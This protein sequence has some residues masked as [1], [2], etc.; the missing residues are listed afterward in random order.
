MLGSPLV[1]IRTTFGATFLGLIISTT[2][3]G[4]TVVQTWTYFLRYYNRDSKALKSFI[5]FVT[6]MDALQTIFSAYVNYWYLVLNFGNVE[7]LEISI[8]AFHTQVIFS[9]IIAS[10]VQLYYA[11]RVHRVSQSIICPTLIVA[12]VTL[13]FSVGMYYA[14]RH[15]VLG[16]LADVLIASSMCWYLHR[17][18]TGF[19][20][21]D[22]IIMTLMLYSINSGL[23]TSILRIVTIISF[24]VLPASLICMAVFSTL[25]K[26]YVNSLLATLNSRDYVYDRSTAANPEN[27]YNLSTIRIE[28]LE[29]HGSIKSRPPGVTVT[30]HHTT[31]ADFGRNRSNHYLDV[32]PTFDNQKEDVSIIPSQN[33]SQKSGSSE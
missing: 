3:F 1:D 27:A 11:R 23:L 30:V 19:A 8:W 18:R 28:P 7:N 14:A 4:L 22:S 13:A 5:L 2:F 20:R 25:V 31:T 9:T 10:A 16:T 17:K 21:T 12:C 24:A 29:G 15:T 32:E 6:V 33:E 26:C